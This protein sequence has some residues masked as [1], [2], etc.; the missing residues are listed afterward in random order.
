MRAGVYGRQSK[1][2]AKSIDEQLTAGHVAIDEHDWTH[3]GDY[4][5]A[6]S[7]SEYGTKPRGGWAQ[8]L[9]DV[10]AGSLDV[11]VLW[12]SDRGD[13]TN[14]TW[15]SFLDLCI[16]HGTRIY[17][18][19]HDRLYDPR[20]DRDWKTL[21]EDGV[22]NAHFSK[23]LSKATRRGH[24]GAAVEGLPPGGPVP[25]GYARQFNPDTG[26]RIG[27]VPIEHQAANVRTLYKRIGKGEPVLRVANDLGLTANAV[28]RIAR[29]P[30]Y[31]AVRTH[32]GKEHQ[33]T[34]PALITPQQFQAAQNVLNTP[35]RRT[36]RPGRQK[37]LLTHM[38]VCDVCSA[39]IEQAVGY[40]RCS[41]KRCVSAPQADAD[42]VM[43]AVMIGRL[44]QPDGIAHLANGTD[45][46]AERAQAEADRLKKQLGEWEDIAKKG[47]DSPTRVA[48]IM[49]DLEQQ[50]EKLQREA[51]AAKLPAMLHE[52][53]DDP[54][55]D[56][57]ARWNNATVVA[58]RAVVRF[59]A[60]VR[61]ARGMPGRTPSILREERAFQRLA[62]SRWRGGDKTWGEIWADEGIG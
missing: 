25:Y 41:V 59:L 7:A 8:V 34:W 2:K 16:G 12:E 54:H 22:A 52:M 32:Q 44:S 26:K 19:T 60:D 49:V 38:A 21:A 50:I 62:P 15:S 45:D 36:T 57:T 53:L 6:V 47:K 1:G 37:W 27:W 28:R 11:L 29:N 51:R 48:G 18:I 40:Y 14:T 9:A 46:A 10:T 5:D 23:K 39:P 31:L 30:L 56:V 33:G 58:Q 24:L 13:R 35:G 3:A 55:A 61:I 4:S 42:D 20:N 17:V 43:T